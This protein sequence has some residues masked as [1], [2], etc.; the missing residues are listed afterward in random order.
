VALVYA[1]R[2]TNGTVPSEAVVIRGLHG[3]EAISERPTEQCRRRYWM[4]VL[5][6]DTIVF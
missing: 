3:D 2:R 4:P 5:S 1:I 6:L